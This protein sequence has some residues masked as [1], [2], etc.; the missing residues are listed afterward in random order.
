MTHQQDRVGIVIQ[1]RM[2]SSRFPG[3]ALQPI[4]GL[5]L[6]KRLTSRLRLCKEPV[7]VLVA[8]SDEPSDDAV[9]EACRSWG[10]EVFRGSEVDLASRMIVAAAIHRM[11]ALVRVTG[12][13]PLTAPEAIDDLIREYRTADWDVVHYN[14][15]GGYI[16]GTGA[17][18]FRIQTIAIC[19]AGLTTAEREDIFWRVRHDPRFSTKALFVAP[20]LNRLS[21]FLTVDYPQDKALL[22]RIYEHFDGRDDIPLRDVIAFLDVRPDLVSINVGLHQQFPE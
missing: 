16:Y 21:Y 11:D 17:E 10:V 20:E 4:G 1:S 12:D 8:T 14:H 2:G 7:A 3:K 6:L 19:A 15:R 18:L 5:P 13:N 9:A 22:D